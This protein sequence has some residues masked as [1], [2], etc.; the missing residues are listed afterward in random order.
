DPPPPRCARVPVSRPP[1]PARAQP[2]AA[3]RTAKARALLVAGW[4]LGLGGAA[5]R[6][7][8]PTNVGFSGFS[9]FDVR[10]PYQRELEDAL[11]GLGPRPMVMCHPGHG[12]ADLSTANVGDDDPV[13]ARR[14]MEYDALMGDR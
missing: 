10:V 5:R 6:R 12:D 3:R 14:R 1:P 13:A 2:P 4:A 8:L 11:R 7:G 9:N